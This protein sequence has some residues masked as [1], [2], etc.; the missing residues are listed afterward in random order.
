M[1]PIW[2]KKFKQAA[3]GGEPSLS[4]KF[5]YGR[6][7]IKVDVPWT[8][9]DDT[10]LCNKQTLLRKA[11]ESP[12]A[13]TPRCRFPEAL[14]TETPK[15]SPLASFFIK[16]IAVA[17]GLPEHSKCLDDRMKAARQSQGP[18]SGC[19]DVYC[20]RFKGFFSVM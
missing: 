10:P 3:R 4:E 16:S 5:C 2:P 11:L 13:P 8:S 14:L 9:D 17:E 20:S 6:T 19:K 7:P 12:Y 18:V 1:L 15:G